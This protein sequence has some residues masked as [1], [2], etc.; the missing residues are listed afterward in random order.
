LCTRTRRSNA[1]E[2]AGV[3]PC[4]RSAAGSVAAGIYR[5]DSGQ[6]TGVRRPQPGLTGDVDS[7]LHYETNVETGAPAVTNDQICR[8]P[9][10]ARL[11]PGGNGREGGPGPERI[12]RLGPQV[13]NRR[14]TTERRRSEQFAAETGLTEIRSQT[15]EVTL[16]DRLQRCVD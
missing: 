2:A 5:R 15:I 9:L 4:D 16:H 12:D 11:M 3:T 10:C 14:Q 13:F 8:E 1:Q 7:V 6:M